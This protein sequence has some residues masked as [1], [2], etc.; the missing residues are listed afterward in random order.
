MTDIT[1][2]GKPPALA[3]RLLS[4]AESARLQYRADIP[5]GVSLDRV[6]QPDFWAHVGLKLQHGTRVE[7]LAQDGSWFAEL[8][9][10][11]STPESCHMWLLSSVDLTAQVEQERPAPAEYVV[12]WGGPQKWR[13]VRVSDKEVVHQGEPTR[14]DADA[15]LADFLKQPA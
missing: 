15:W 5:P 6:M 9:V 12:A 2:Q 10:R 7:C 8:M 14:A 13:I 3:P 1:H 11:K 4:F